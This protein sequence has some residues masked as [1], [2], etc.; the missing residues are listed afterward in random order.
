[1]LSHTPNQVLKGLIEVHKLSI[2]P[3]ACKERT[4]KRRIFL[5]K[6]TLLEI[7]GGCEANKA[8]ENFDISHAFT[9]PKKCL[10]SRAKNRMIMYNLVLKILYALL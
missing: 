6:R 9:G 7:I 4:E 8:I 10:Q 3:N 1:L 2:I 5:L